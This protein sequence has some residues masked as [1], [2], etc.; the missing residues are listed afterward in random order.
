MLHNV[1]VLTYRL[2]SIKLINDMKDK[3]TL[4]VTENKNLLYS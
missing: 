3:I 1:L 4:G 2:V